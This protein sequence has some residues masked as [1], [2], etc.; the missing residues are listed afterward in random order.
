MS[1]KIYFIPL[2]E[3]EEIKGQ[4]LLLKKPFTKEEKKILQKI[5]Q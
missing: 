1:I 4:Y 2:S 5:H 3:I